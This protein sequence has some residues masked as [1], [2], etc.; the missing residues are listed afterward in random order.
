MG[1]RL[2]RKI[3]ANV[4]FRYGSEADFEGVEIPV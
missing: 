3:E 4:K 2:N 1:R